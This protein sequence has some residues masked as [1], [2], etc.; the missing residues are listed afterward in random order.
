[1]QTQIEIER[2]YLVEV[3]GDLPA[4]ETTEI[5]QTYLVAG[6]GFSR[7]V[8]KRGSEGDWRYYFTEKQ[9]LGPDRRIETEGEIGEAEYRQ[10][11]VEADPKRETI[12]KKRTCFDWQGQSFELDDYD[13]PL[14]LDI[15]FVQEEVAVEGLRTGACQI[16]ELEGAESAEAVRMPPFI[17]VIRD[18]TGDHR[19][20]N[21][22]LAKWLRN[23]S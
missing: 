10:L 6:K 20:V 5:V 12:R 17:R 18:V 9:P 22:Q 2:K 23:H 7:R 4:G 16:L 19:Y 13:R 14:L 1:M 21:S 3:V 15:D 11:L 8:R